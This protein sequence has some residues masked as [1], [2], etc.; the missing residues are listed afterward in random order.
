MN[1]YYIFCKLLTFLLSLGQEGIFCQV[2]KPV[3]CTM[4][5]S[6][7]GGIIR[8]REGNDCKMNI[9]SDSDKVHRS[10]CQCAIIKFPYIIHK[11][12]LPKYNLCPDFQTLFSSSFGTA[13]HSFFKR[14][15][16]SFIQ[17]IFIECTRHCSMQ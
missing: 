3:A 6:S 15:L 1:F 9:K 10:L 14:A 8:T 11:S 16:L 17:H 12:F 5:A 13:N 4:R 7:D 2:Y